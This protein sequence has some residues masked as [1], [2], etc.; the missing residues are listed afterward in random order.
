MVQS[1]VPKERRCQWE[2]FDLSC[3]W[4]HGAWEGSSSVPWAPHR[5]CLIG[6]TRV[7]RVSLSQ[8]GLE[9]TQVEGRSHIHTQGLWLESNTDE[10]MVNW[11]RPQ[12]GVCTHNME[13]EALG[14]P[15]WFRG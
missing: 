15:W 6:W 4:D 5:P 9:C 13:Q 2:S 7:S 14:L 1:R 12:Q 11:V 10:L 3:I 8:P